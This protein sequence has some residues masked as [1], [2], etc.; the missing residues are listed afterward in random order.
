MRADALRR[1]VIVGGGTA[2]SMAAAA[3]VDY[4]HRIGCSNAGLKRAS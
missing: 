2:G 3:M 4:L 1:V